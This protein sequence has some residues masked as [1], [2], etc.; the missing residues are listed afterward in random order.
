LAFNKAEA[1][2]LGNLTA[3]GRVIAPDSLGEIDDANRA[4]PLDDDEQRKQRAIERDTCFL[5]G[6]SRP[7]L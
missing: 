5:G 3:D 4:P 1:F 7:L 6:R 2:Q